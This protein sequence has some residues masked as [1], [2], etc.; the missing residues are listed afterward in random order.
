MNIIE[1]LKQNAEKFG[2]KAALVHHNQSISY[3][4]LEKKSQQAANFFTQ[5]NISAGQKALLF[6]PLSIEFYVLF[7]GLVRSGVTVILLDPSA[8]K[9]HISTCVHSIKPNAFI[10]TTK[11]HLLRFIPEVAA[12]HKKF[13]T[14]H[15][16]PGSRTINYTI[17]RETYQDFV[18]PTKHPALIT[19]TSGSTGTPKGIARS[20]SFLINQHKAISY[21]LS[22]SESDIELNT[23]P[24]FILS[25]LAN[26]ITTVIPNSN[27]KKPADID[28]KQI[29][30]QINADKV[31]RILAAPAFCKALADHLQSQQQT[32][33]AIKKVYTGGGSVF[34]NLLKQ[35]KKNLPNAEIIAVYGSTEAEPIAHISIDDINEDALQQM[36]QGKGLLVGKP[37]SDI[38]LAIIA[39]KDGE[40]IG[41]FTDETFKQIAQETRQGEIVVSGKHVQK[42]YISGD[43]SKTKFKVN[44]N[45]WHRTGDAGYLDESGRLWLLGRCSAKI[46]KRDKI[47][48]PF[49][50]EAAAMAFLGVNRAAVVEING[51]ITLAIES[52]INDSKQ[53]CNKIKHH[54]TDIDT[55][56]VLAN[57]PMDKRHN[58]KVLY[59]ELKKQLSSSKR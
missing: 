33:T 49:G 30:R 14:H 54:L 10:A 15:W 38:E 26:G 46:V 34:P 55:I 37:T 22:M 59:A 8:G 3:R 25:N 21:S 2:E 11:A 23:L 24:V 36:Q 13:S 58:S 6:V 39:D 51:I 45:I 35:L 40:V 41:S 52:S 48:Y 31:N 12:I 56:Q 50:L 17:P 42:S 32:L 9:T 5:Q 28:A 19:F 20:H 43:E 18:T 29:I 7:L 47:I 4:A 53:L 44:D 16:L 1:L 27:V 57:I